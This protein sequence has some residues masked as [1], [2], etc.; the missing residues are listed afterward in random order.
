M[1]KVEAREKAKSAGLRQPAAQDCVAEKF[2]TMLHARPIPS[3][4][5]AE[6]NAA[7]KACQ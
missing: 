6:L 7:I 4:A 3:Q 2:V 1:A 5:P